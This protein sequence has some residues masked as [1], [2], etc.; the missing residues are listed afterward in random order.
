MP[1][2]VQLSTKERALFA[3][4]IQEYEMRKYHPALKTADAIL[5]RA[6]DH[7]ET[8]AL[9][10]LILFSL[11]RRE[12]GLYMAKLGVRRDLTSFICWHALGIV[13]R[14][15]RNY[16]EALKCYA[17]ALKIE[18]GNINIVRESAL[19]QLQMRNYVPLIEARLV[20][21]R[22]QPHY[23]PN[24]IALAIAHDVAGSTAQAARVLAGYE[25]VHRDVPENNY[26]FSEVV[27]YHASL[28]EHMGDADGVLALSLIHI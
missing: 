13:Y 16:E 14:M 7:G 21:L 27:L 10:G 20:L 1:P 5:A 15:D 17:Q 6:P 28:L 9:K 4:L 24:W 23:R 3:R 19:L 8:I 22:T 2:K 12:E 11:Q 18:G 26:E 25:D